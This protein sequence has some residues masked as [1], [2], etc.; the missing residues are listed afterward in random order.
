MGVIVFYITHTP[1]PE[2]V[3]VPLLMLVIALI[4]RT[5][6][7]GALAPVWSI[8]RDGRLV[9][10]VIM[11]FLTD[12]E[13]T[14]AVWFWA[15]VA[16]LSWPMYSIVWYGWNHCFAPTA[17]VIPEQS[18]NRS[19]GEPTTP[20]IMSC[21]TTQAASDSVVS[22]RS[23]LEG[24]KNECQATGL[25]LKKR[26]DQSLSDTTCANGNAVWCRV[27]D[28]D[29]RHPDVGKTNR[30]EDECEW[31]QLGR[32]HE[33]R[34]EEWNLAKQCN[35]RNCSNHRSGTAVQ[36]A[37]SKVCEHHMGQTSVGKD[38]GKESQEGTAYRPD[39]RN[40]R[41]PMSSDDVS[42]LGRV[43]KIQKERIPENVLREGKENQTSTLRQ[44]KNA[45]IRGNQG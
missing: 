38:V 37:L 1:G 15:F 31:I 43:M 42:A 12:S 19:C 13:G 27:T 16:S 5:I 18:D 30:Y 41:G 17:E 20:S 7:I 10:R 23:G 8:L 39:V 26:S 2:D 24:T 4:S 44:K 32:E 45:Q 3:K 22:R 14:I 28:S 25:F 6:G 33:E 35:V 9:V 36:G 21:A 34:Y 29:S 40:G 11:N